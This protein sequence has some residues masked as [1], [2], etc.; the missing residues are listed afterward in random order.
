MTEDFLH[1]IWKYGL[2]ERSGMIADTGEEIQIISLGEHNTNAG[3]DFQNARIK[4][5]NATWAGNVEVHL[6]SSD[7]YEHKHHEDKAFNN[8][9]LHVVQRHNQRISRSSGEIIP[10]VEL[11]FDPGLS[12]NYSHLLQQEGWLPCRNKIR[13]VDPFLFDVWLNSLVVERLQQKTDYLAGLLDHY[14]NDWEEV[15]Y[16]SLARAFGFGLNSI[17]FEMTA[18]SL[19]FRHLARHRNDLFQIEAMLMGQAGFLDEAVLFS[20]YY[21]QLR[22]EYLHLK[23][24]YKLKPVEKHL[25]KFLRIRPVNFP[26]I[27]IAQFA[28]LIT[29]SEGLFSY[30]LSCRTIHELR[31]FFDV[32]ASSFWD[33]HYSFESSSPVRSKTLGKEAF[34]RIVINTVIPVLFI[35]GKLNATEEPMERALQWLMQIPPEKNRITEHWAGQG[36][37]P[38]S[39]FYSQ[40]L[41]QLSSHYCYK[42]RCLACSIGTKIITLQ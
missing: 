5:G 3:P 13:N 29:K 22:K 41:L 28:G 37:K 14:K 33:S 23:N 11:H 8:V 30:M 35:Y 34:L 24:K 26:T 19:P 12:E 18:R 1:F 17:P 4:I 38:V 42:K 6:R 32:R 7:W 31:K 40:G 25:W 27:R 39:A 16:I 20:D 36:K 21:G 2:F 9:I 10:T 15:F